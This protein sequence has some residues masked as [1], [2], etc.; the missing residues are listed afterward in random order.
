MHPIGRWKDLRFE[1]LFFEK[2][3]LS[4][5]VCFCKY[6]ILVNSQLIE[7]LDGRG[8]WKDL[9]HIFSLSL[10]LFLYLYPPVRVVC[11]YQYGAQLYTRL[12]TVVN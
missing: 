9:I 2:I 7:T 10:I 8:R 4:I 11:I 6:H 5:Y 1:T 12:N 3:F